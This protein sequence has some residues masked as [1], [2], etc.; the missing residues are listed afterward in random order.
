[1]YKKI[2]VDCRMIEHSGIGTYLKNILPRIIKMESE[3]QFVLL[4]N[5]EK[6]KRYVDFSSTNL[7]LIESNAKIFSLREQI[8][9]VK[10]IPSDIDFLW[11]PHFNI[12]IFYSGKL[13]VTIHDVM[14]LALPK[15][16]GG[17][18]K[19]FFARFLFFVLKKRA[20]KILT[21][22]EFTKKEIV[23][24]I[25]IDPLKIF[26]I[27]LGVFQEI[28]FEEDELSP[29]EKKYIL[30]VGNIK[31]HKNLVTLINAFNL[32][33]KKINLD[34]IV[35]GE[36][37]KLRT[38]DD[39]I[40]QVYEKDSENI[41]FTGFITDDLLKQYY[42]H[43]T[44]LIFPSYYEGFG[45]PVLEAMAYGCPVISSTSASL[46]EVGG[47]A[48]MYFNPNSSDELAGKIISLY[49]NKKLA[50]DMVEKGL[51]QVKNFSWDLCAEKT[52]KV[53]KMI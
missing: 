32:I 34:L 20:F 22:S 2:C 27:P 14:Q 46:P 18:H 39:E 26:P 33:K 12:P 17:I 4:G 21:V 35:V 19:Q 9:L 8:D 29:H 31:K 23:K 50:K 37:E 13:L 38:A 36:K 52:L 43:A 28:K 51:L 47:N 25:G 5:K 40:S 48:V 16:A 42:R 53:L 3:I 6:L 41:F 44:A 15:Y 30:F 45:L 24:L 49:E 11:V 7:L 1:L 10:N